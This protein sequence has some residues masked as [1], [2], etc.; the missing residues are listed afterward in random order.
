MKFSEGHLEERLSWL[1]LLS[2]I[3]EVYLL[4]VPWYIWGTT[5]GEKASTCITSLHVHL[6]STAAWHGVFLFGKG[7]IELPVVAR[8]SLGLDEKKKTE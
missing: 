2:P 6:H 4:R 7:Y 3:A 5:G 1:A 8:L